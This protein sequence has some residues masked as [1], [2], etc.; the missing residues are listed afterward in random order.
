MATTWP[1]VALYAVMFGFMGLSISGWMLVDSYFSGKRS[2]ERARAHAEVE[3]TR[4][5]ALEKLTT[6]Y[7]KQMTPEQ[8][9]D[10]AESMGLVERL[11]D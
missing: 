7:A 9:R 4:L 11:G 2:V 5:S 8:F 6:A 10:Y 3:R 1:D